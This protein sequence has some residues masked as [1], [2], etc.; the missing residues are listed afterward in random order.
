MHPGQQKV[1]GQESL[2]SSAGEGELELLTVPLCR[3]DRRDGWLWS[4]KAS[5]L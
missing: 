2:R 4:D 3:L 5:L 1:T